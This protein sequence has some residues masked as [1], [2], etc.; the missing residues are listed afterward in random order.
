M[1]VEFPPHELANTIFCMKLYLGKLSKCW[2]ELLDHCNA[3]KVMS[4]PLAI[5]LQ[6]HSHC[7][8]KNG[9]V[10]DNVR[11][12]VTPLTLTKDYVAMRVLHRKSPTEESRVTRP[13]KKHKQPHKNCHHGGRAAL[14]SSSVDLMHPHRLRVGSLAHIISESAAKL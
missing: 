4:A 11:Q 3:S 13:H 7:W 12:K 1:F 10:Q 2:F 5:I 9:M 8:E 14:P 6:I